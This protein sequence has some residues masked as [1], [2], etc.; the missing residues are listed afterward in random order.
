MGIFNKIFGSEKGQ[1][2][3]PTESKGLQEE[4]GVKT[5]KDE[6]RGTSKL[7]QNEV[8]KAKDLT[9]IVGAKD[10]KMGTYKANIGRG[11]IGYFDPWKVV[12]R[13]TSRGWEITWPPDEFG[14][15]ATLVGSTWVEYSLK[16]GHL[17]TALGVKGNVFGFGS[18][19]ED[20]ETFFLNLMEVSKGE[21]G[22]FIHENTVL[23]FF[24][25]YSVGEKII[26]VDEVMKEVT[27]NS[28]INFFI[29]EVAVENAENMRQLKKLSEEKIR[30]LRSRGVC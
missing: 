16:A 18:T 2:K 12:V 23:P 13:I 1:K 29:S 25:K 24:R 15:P 4:V 26:V 22:S 7:K 14:A 8:K 3:E 11:K 28:L 20:M 17:Q 27:L 30:E 10:A 19:K 21:V 6:E 5:M 9:Y